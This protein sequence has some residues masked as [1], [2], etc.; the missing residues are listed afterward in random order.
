MVQ[1]IS[2]TYIIP[3]A[4]STI[5]GVEAKNAVKLPSVPNRIFYTYINNST[6]REEIWS[7][8]LVNGTPVN[9][10][11]AKI[12]TRFSGNDP[13]V[14]IKEGNNIST[15]ELKN[16]PK[17]LSSV[18]IQNQLRNAY[19]QKLVYATFSG[20]GPNGILLSHGKLDPKN[21]SVKKT[22]SQIYSTPTN[23]GNGTPQ[24]APA[25]TSNQPSDNPDAPQTG[26]QQPTP[27]E[28]TSTRTS[29]I[30]LSKVEL[31]N[32]SGYKDTNF[33]LKYGTTVA[34][35]TSIGET[36]QDYIQFDVIKY[37]TRSLSEKNHFTF[38]KRYDN[39]RVQTAL[40]S[41]I[42]PIQPNVSDANMVS[43][44][45]DVISAVELGL[46]GISASAAAGTSVDSIVNGIMAK[47]SSL[48]T[49]GKFSESV[50]EALKMFFSRKAANPTGESDK[51]MSRILGSIIN[52]NMELI[53]NAPQLRP[54]NFNFQ[55]TPRSENEGEKVKNII[56][57][58]KEASAV[59]RGIGDLFLKA[60]YVFQLGYKTYQDGKYIL[61][62]SINKFKICALQNV[63]VDY[64]PTGMYSTYDDQFGTMT[65]YNLSLQFSEIEPIF[66]D[67]YFGDTDLSIVGY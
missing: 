13:Y 26:S 32:V 57:I 61:H 59:R 45:Q 46:T 64:T 43:W 60:P 18:I 11:F 27:D 31:P 2:D 66:A 8:K 37:N 65:A 35:P 44:N 20:S 34:Y 1:I 50:K 22:I 6:G 39:R 15:A 48:D 52:P 5:R 51:F 33:A 21:P 7:K 28:K 56:R 38:N 63:S 47:I 25:T 14:I 49:E 10:S 58:F 30:D 3:A 4:R 12:A 24:P 29:F 17:D 9:S 41:I 67:D 53:F 36:G 42:L 54:F 62:P 23:P 40:I 19:S 16:I 55:L